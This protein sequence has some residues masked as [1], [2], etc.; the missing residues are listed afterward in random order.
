MDRSPV[1]NGS[2]S[3]LPRFATPSSNMERMKTFPLNLYPVLVGSRLIRPELDV[4]RSFIPEVPGSIEDPQIRKHGPNAE[5][6][7]NGM[8]ATPRLDHGP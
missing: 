3:K 6:R 2:A 7:S 5:T 8:Q 1:Q 4:H